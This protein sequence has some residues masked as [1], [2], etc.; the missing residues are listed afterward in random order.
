[1]FV[2]L[3]EKYEIL[4]VFYLVKGLDAKGWWFEFPFSEYD[5]KKHAPKSYFEYYREQGIFKIS[6]FKIF[7][8]MKSRRERIDEGFEV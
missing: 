5:P 1:M 8:R 2:L 4:I 6:N 3:N 7:V